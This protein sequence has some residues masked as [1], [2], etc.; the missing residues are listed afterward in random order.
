MQKIKNIILK[1]KITVT[2]LKIMQVFYTFFAKFAAISLLIV[3]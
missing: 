3:Q 1:A 2:K